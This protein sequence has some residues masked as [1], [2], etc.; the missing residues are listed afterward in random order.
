MT[1]QSVSC[2]TLRELAIGGSS[3]RFHRVRRGNGWAHGLQLPGPFPLA[4]VVA[5]QADLLD[6]G[7]QLQGS[8]TWLMAGPPWVFESCLRVLL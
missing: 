6:L 5:G 4:G 7:Q 1:F 8:L 2:L 3:P